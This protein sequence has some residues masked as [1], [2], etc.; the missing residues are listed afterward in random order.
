MRGCH[1]GSL[2]AFLSALLLALASAGAHAQSFGD[3]AGRMAGTWLG[4]GMASLLETTRPA[5]VPFA[6]GPGEQ[7]SALAENLLKLLPSGTDL[8]LAATGFRTLGE[9]VTAAHASSYLAI[10]FDALKTRIIAG[11]A[12]GAAIEALRPEVDGFVEA[13]RARTLAREDLRRG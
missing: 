4:V 11:D 13:R 6:K 9:F 7:T 10:S 5:D 3:I 8:K 1:G 2:F 12:I